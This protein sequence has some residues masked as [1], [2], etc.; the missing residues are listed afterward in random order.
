MSLF[1]VVISYTNQLKPIDHTGHILYK[2]IEIKSNQAI[3]NSKT[4]PNQTHVTLQYN[5]FFEGTILFQVISNH[6]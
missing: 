2:P 1:S 6:A 3:W 5:T 4:K